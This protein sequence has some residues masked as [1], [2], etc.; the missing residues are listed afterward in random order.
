[1]ARIQ[2]YSNDANVNPS[3][4]LLGSDNDSGEAT[5]NYLISDLAAYF[6]SSGGD[7]LGDH[8]ATENLN[9]STYDRILLTDTGN[10]SIYFGTGGED[11]TSGI[12][13]STFGIRSGNELTTGGD[14]AFFGNRAGWLGT[15]T[16]DTVAIGSGA[17]IH[18]Q[19]DGS[20]IIGYLAGTTAD[21]QFATDLTD[22]VYIGRQAE[23]LNPTGMVDEIVIGAGAKGRGSN[24]AQV[25][26]VT[27][28]GQTA[29]QSIGFGDSIFDFSGLTAIRTFTLPNSSGTLALTT[30]LEQSQSNFTPTLTSWTG[31]TAVPTGHYV[32]TGVLVH[33][34]IN[35]AFNGTGGAGLGT[36]LLISLPFSVASDDKSIAIASSFSGGSL[37]RST[38]GALS[39]P[40]LVAIPNA[41]FSTISLLLRDGS[42]LSSESW[43]NVIASSGFGVRISGTYYTTA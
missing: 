8:T 28:I 5:R 10:R 38:G 37:T 9:L 1:M 7:N 27:D 39:S 36:D 35:I 41:G 29:L 22:V 33:F 32:K 25:G 26:K 20:V 18:N 14:N 12:Q 16:S 40:S 15:G 31:F 17:M 4:R 11:I 42:D 6:N 24:T 43:A 21:N 2:T 19:S 3:D 23:G 13:N 34:S 30:D